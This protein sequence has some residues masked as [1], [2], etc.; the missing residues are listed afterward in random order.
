MPNPA[1]PLLV[2]GGAAL[3]LLGG[4][5]KRKSSDEYI[6]FEDE[7]VIGGGG[8]KLSS[9]ESVAFTPDLDAFEIGATW[10]IRVL[11]Q[12]LN[13]RRKAGH[14]ATVNRNAVWLY[15]LLV[16]SPTTFLGDITGL[17]KTGGTVIYGGL[18]LMATLGIGVYA[19]GFAAAGANIQA[20]TQAANATRA[21]QIL[22]P[23]ATQLAGQ[24][25]RKGFG[26][27]QIALALMDFGGM[28]QMAKFGVAKAIVKLS[29]GAAGVGGSMAAALLAE[30]GVDSIYSA[31]LAA[32]A[33][34]AAGDFMMTHNVEVAGESVPIALLPS[35][36]DYPAVQ[37][38]NMIIMEYILKFQ[39]RTFED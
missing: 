34:E 10:R 16:D 36:D 25:Y 18:W 15:N 30:S 1:L 31:D 7:M 38:F 6:E 23:K 24:L 28:E 39:K 9:N 20:A 14:L 33:T 8:L 4:K 5:K 19:S 26:S 3:L 11:D 2:A 27:S 17:G 22:G 21:M 13:E 37:E 12:W 32:S 35:G 29:G